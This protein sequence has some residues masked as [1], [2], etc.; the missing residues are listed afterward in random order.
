MTEGVDQ[1]IVAG[2]T[3]A[4]GRGVPV[5]L[6]FFYK[7]RARGLKVSAHNWLALLDALG[8]DLHESSLDGF[9]AVARCILVNDEGDYDAFD[10]AFGETFRGLI[11]DLEH[12]ASQ[13]EQWLRDPKQLLHLDPALRALIEEIGLEEL[14][15]QLLERLAE[16]KKRHEG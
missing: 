6:D 3:V 5:F 12:M 14:R 9:Y 10:L 7:L 1:A 16:Q 15:R 11:T 2:T 4:S 13:L 8:Q